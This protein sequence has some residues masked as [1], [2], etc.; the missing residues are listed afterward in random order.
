V[1]TE[2]YLDNNATTPPLPGVVD[3]VVAC[4]KQDYG[5][6]SSPHGRGQGSRAKLAQAREH[7]AS[8]LGAE[9]DQIIFTAGATE[10]NN[11]VLKSLL[12]QGGP[13]RLITTPIEHSS[14]LKVAEHLEHRGL[15]VTYLNVDA[16]GRVTPDQLR[17][18]L[19]EPA[20]LVSI[21]WA[22]S[23][24]GVVQ[25]IAELGQVCREYG[26]PLHVDAAQAVGRM[27]VNLAELPIDYLTFTG[28]KLHGPQGTG[29]LFA[30]DRS[31]LVPLVH[32]GDQEHDRRAGTENV[33]GIAGLGRAAAE[34]DQSLEQATRHMQALRDRFEEAILSRVEDLY[35][36]GDRNNRVCN[37]SNIRFA[38]IEGQALMAQ[39]DRRR[40]IC[41]QTSACTS[42]RPE[43]SYVLRTLGLTDDEAFASVRFSFSVLNTAEEVDQAV[44]S[45]AEVCDRL[46]SFA[47][48]AG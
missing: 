24:T 40:V 29:A 25:P 19:A 42:Q 47:R 18:A 33:P 6:P 10:G 3:E 48:M 9:S 27:T 31:R 39:L 41:S 4:L 8:F 44:D 43:P 16:T 23:E 1:S 22:N 21:Q 2:I 15:T 20:E 37:T 26:V 11:T 12:G 7:I 45:I 17:A 13:A 38:G 30:R 32:G 5:N 46:R 28:H 35:V 36:N 34:R 14:V